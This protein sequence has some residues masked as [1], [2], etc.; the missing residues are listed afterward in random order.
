LVGLGLLLDGVQAGADV[1]DEIGTEVTGITAIGVRDR[2]VG[3]VEA[4]PLDPVRRLVRSAV[5]QG[6]SVPELGAT[7]DDGASVVETVST[8]G[9]APGSEEVTGALGEGVGSGD[10]VGVGTTTSTGAGFVP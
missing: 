9:G 6:T 3:D 2:L 7:F 8:G 1:P 4:V 10:G 5:L